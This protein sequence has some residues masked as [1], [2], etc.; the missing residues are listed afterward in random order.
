[1][2]R[3]YKIIIFIF[4]VCFYSN[5]FSQ[6]YY[7]YHT[8]KLN[9]KI[10]SLE[11]DS[12]YIYAGCKSGYLVK[13]DIQKKDTISYKIHS[14]KINRIAINSKYVATSSSDKQIKIFDVKTF[15]LIKE[16]KTQVNTIPIVFFNDSTILLGNDNGYVLKKNFFNNTTDT[17][18]SNITDK[19]YFRVT[20][21]L[22]NKVKNEI[23]I[24]A[25]DIFILDDKSY[26]LKKTINSPNDDFSR[27]ANYQYS[28]CVW[29]Y[30]QKKLFYYKNYDYKSNFHKIIKSKNSFASSI[31]FFNSNT[32][33]TGKDNTSLI[34]NIKTSNNHS[35]ANHTGIVI[36]VCKTPNN[37]FIANGGFDKNLDIY[38][39][40]KYKIKKFTCEDVICNKKMTLPNVHFKGR[41]DVFT[42]TT[43]ASND[44]NEFLCYINKTKNIKTIFLYGY[45]GLKAPKIVSKKRADK[46]K[47]ILIREGIKKEEIIS[48]GMGVSPIID[49]FYREKNR[50]VDFE[51]ICNQKV[52]SEKQILKKILIELKEKNDTNIIDVIYKQNVLESFLLHNIINKEKLV[53]DT[54]NIVAQYNNFIF[55]TKSIWVNSKTS[56]IKKDKIIIT[57][58][59]NARLGAG[60][61]YSKLGNNI[62][63]TGNEFQF[64]KK[65]KNNNDIWYKFY[66]WGYISLK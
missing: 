61:K 34:Y 39:Y 16:I 42:D 33:L 41:V 47:Q 48:I 19:Y 22:H 36:S 63:K 25:G 64:V 1:M 30:M 18:F 26:R 62:L 12:N 10:I 66:I 23:L 58:N 40:S 49:R 59:S 24:C 43:F 7:P 56:Q 2:Y 8:I 32:I 14:K 31:C 46:I 20:D 65:K 57:K 17:I 53:S 51:L 6:K 27:I 38:E 15:D 11:A 60:L 5:A 54:I 37:K 4:S 45:T 35:F 29:S 28:L 52:L 50:R 44:I 21:I 55:F 9:S 3:Y 13:Y